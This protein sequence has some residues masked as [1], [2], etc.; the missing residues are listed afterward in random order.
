MSTSE[1]LPAAQNPAQNPAPAKKE[2]KGYTMEEL[3]YQKALAALRKEFCKSNMLHS[4]EG[5]KHPLRSSG[6]GSSVPLLGNISRTPAVGQVA[7][8]AKVVAS[9]V[10]RGM[11]PWDYVMLGISLIG[12]TRKLFKLFRKKKK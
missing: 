8:V 3:Q 10:M 5:L 11:K 7:S 9:S 4:V 1:K 6:S 2:F 12:P